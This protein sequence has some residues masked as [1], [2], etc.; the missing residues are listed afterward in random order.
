MR[1]RELIKMGNVE[2]H[3]LK[4]FTFFILP[5]K[6]SGQFLQ[7]LKRMKN[8]SNGND[9]CFAALWHGVTS[10]FGKNEKILLKKSTLALSKVKRNLI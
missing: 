10:I 9:S 6:L 8:V 3:I 5:H 7:L 4:V 1:F 2:R